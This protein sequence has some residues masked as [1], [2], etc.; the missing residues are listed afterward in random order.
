MN[1]DAFIDA[2]NAANSSADVFKEFSLVV[3]RIGFDRIIYCGIGM[4][5]SPAI[6]SNYPDEW[7]NHYAEKGY[8]RTDPARAYCAVARKPF[9]WSDVVRTLP[10]EKVVIFNEAAECGVKDGIGIAIHE[11]S[12]ETKGIALASSAGGVDVRPFLSHLHLIALQFH[13]AFSAQQNAIVNPFYK[14]SPRERE[15]L[16][17]LAQG[18]SKWVIGELLSI[19]SHA[20]DYH[21]RNIFRKLNVSSSRMAVIKGIQL[22]LISHG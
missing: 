3:G 11:P 6:I 16:L 10:K 19:S 1:V 12:G 15:V 5:E 13:I 7:L 22:G 8:V 17:W 20:I 18:K 14:L 4:T 2:T 9:L 21:C